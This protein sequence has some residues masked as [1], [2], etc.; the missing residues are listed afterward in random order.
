MISRSG[1]R[2]DILLETLETIETV[3]EH[4]VTLVR[5]NQGSG[6]AKKFLLPTP[7]EVKIVEESLLK[8]LETSMN[9]RLRLRDE[10]LCTYFSQCGSSFPPASADKFGGPLGFLMKMRERTKLPP[11]FFWATRRVV[12]CSA[13]GKP[14]REQI[15]VVSE[16]FDCVSHG[17]QLLR[18]RWLVD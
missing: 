8:L 16:L 11:S 9:Y 1:I 5:H 3:D 18:R 10:L 12:G 6:S 13:I 7:M 15:E 2:L 17:K 14:E 4:G